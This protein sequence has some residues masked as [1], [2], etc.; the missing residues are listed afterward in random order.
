MTDSELLDRFRAGAGATAEA[1]FETLVTRHGPMVLRVCRSVLPSR[2]DVEDAFQATFLVLVHRAHAI[3]EGE[4]LGAWLHGV[5]RRVALRMKTT[6]RKR[7]SWEQR[8]SERSELEENNG[9]DQI[10]LHEE[11]ERLPEKYRAP[12]VLCYLEGMTHDEAAQQLGWPVGTVR[13]RLSRARNVLRTRL[14][15]GRDERSLWLPTLGRSGVPKPASVPSP[16][17]L[18]TVSAAVSRTAETAPSIGLPGTPA[19]AIAR[20]VALATA[21]T[22]LK[23]AV[24]ACLAIAL[25]VPALGFLSRTAPASAPARTRL[26]DAPSPALSALSATARDRRRLQ[27]SWIIVAREHSF[28]TVLPGPEVLPRP[29]LG[30]G[31]LAMLGPLTETGSF[32]LRGPVVKRAAFKPTGTVP[33]HGV[34]RVHGP[35]GPA[36]KGRSIRVVDDRFALDQGPGPMFQT[37]APPKTEGTIALDA[38]ASPKRIELIWP[39]HVSKGIYQLEDDRLQVCLHDIAGSNTPVGPAGEK[40]DSCLTLV[41]ERE[42]PEGAAPSGHPAR[43]ADRAKPH[44]LPP[45]LAP[46]D[47]ARARTLHA[48]ARW[49]AEHVRARQEE[50]GATPFTGDEIARLSDVIEESLALQW[51]FPDFVAQ[52]SRRGGAYESAGMVQTEQFI[53]APVLSPGQR[54]WRIPFMTRWE[55]AQVL[56]RCGAGPWELII[57]LADKRP[58]THSTTTPAVH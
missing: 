47:P 29:F 33:G 52:H 32:F 17:I 25:S 10:G 28:V 53:P 48:V 8:A 13:S 37:S 51:T 41:L 18:A 5:A 39:D 26:T 58:P 36:L 56:G 30:P 40:H 31:P 38:S 24:A 44:A 55:G 3:R 14:A 2:E 4:S 46:H 9:P 34:V 54:G 11:L 35:H 27:G 42:Q 1:A 16:L 7:R 57:D 49:R 19:V 20:E 50:L 45:V 15:R 21:R 12:V 43:A 6:E 22:R 23:L